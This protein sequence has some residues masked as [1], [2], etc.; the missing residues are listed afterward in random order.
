[1]AAEV[2]QTVRAGANL[3]L[4]EATD[5]TQ[6]LEP[7][8]E[9]LTVDVAI[10]GAGIAGLSIAYTL[11]RAGLIVAVI[12]DGLIG[13]GMTGRTTAHLVNALDDRY[14]DLEKY[15]G[16]DG[17]MMAAQ[18]HSAAIDRIEQ[19]VRE[20]RIECDFE[21]LDGYLFEPPNQSLK[22]LEKEFDACQRCGLPVEWVKRAPIEDFDTHRAIR[23]PRQGQFHPLRYLRGLARAIL[24]RGGRIFT[25]SKVVEAEGGE[26]AFV[27]T[28]DGLNVAAKSI[29]VATNS[30]I[31]DRYVIHTKQ[32]PYTTY[33]VALRAKRHA[34]TPAL[35]WDTAERAGM[36]SGI[37]PG[38]YHYVRLADSGRN[39]EEIL[40]VGGEDHKSGQADD[41]EV[42]FQRL[43][44]WA[45]TRW[46]QAKE[47]V[48]HWSGQVM[49]PVDSLGYI[50]R[51]PADKDNVYVVTGDSGN[52]MTH[53]TIAGMLIPEL[54]LRG[55]HAWEKLYDPSRITPRTA[56]DFAKENVNVAVQYMDYFGR[57]DVKSPDDLKPG[58][59]AVFRRGLEKLAI[60][61]DDNG[62]VHEFSAICPHL[63][64]IV[65][66]DRTEKSW[67]CPCHG[68]R[69]DAQGH[70][71]NGPS[72]AD[73]AR[74]GEDS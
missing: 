53:G 64:C 9:N 73:L 37:G 16:Q 59:G 7:L 13:R 23:F 26:Q 40:I 46:P 30:P 45:R 66:W 21:R 4:W 43:E 35:Y 42:R 29:V 62:D 5:I 63:K 15:F 55:H 71:I 19:I 72:I 56:P 58:E 48:F 32:A 1:M 36:E 68:S 20:E 24:E 10:V 18:S 61:R 57:G 49:E 74:C 47:I 25:G 41:A 44:N 31:N 54:I 39:D 6:A 3:S 65:H 70:V 34:I 38:P 67:D 60:Y 69:F 27:K 11:T 14:Y 2:H 17:A 50:G 51:N 52:G 33:V 12:D 22:N 8:R 28:G